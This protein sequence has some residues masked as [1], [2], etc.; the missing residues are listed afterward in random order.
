MKNYLKFNIDNLKRAFGADIEK[1]YNRSLRSKASKLCYGVGVL[2]FYQLAANALNAYMRKT[3]QQNEAEKA[4]KD[5]S[6]V[7]K[8]KLAYPDGMKWYD[9]LMYSNASG[10]GTHIFGGRYKDGK[11]MYIR[12]GKQFR[13]FP[14]MFFDDNWHLSFPA[15]IWERMF[16]KANP[17]IHLVS[18][19]TGFY[20]DYNNTAQDE[21]IKRKY[22]KE[23]GT[24][25]KL[26]NYYLPY[27]LNTQS[28]KEFRTTDLVFP[29]SKGYNN[30]KAQEDFKKYIMN[31]DTPGISKTYQNCVLNGI[32]PQLQMNAAIASIKAD[33]KTE[34]NDG[35]I[36]LGKAKEAFENAK[37]VEEKKNYK[38]KI[39]KYLANEN[40]GDYSMQ[41]AIDEAKDILTGQAP[42]KE[43]N[44]VYISKAT[45]QDVL[46][47][48]RLSSIR[49]KVK[50]HTDIINDLRDTDPA[51]AKA[52]Y[53]SH[54]KW[55]EIDNVIKKANKQ[56]NA[57]KK[58]MKKGKGDANTMNKIRETRTKALRELEGFNPTM[59]K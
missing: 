12:W 43:S 41:N 50:K 53:D 46:D 9:Y 8:Y 45:Y 22:G 23:V 24:L 20:S 58:L 47:D 16:T 3:D 44:D 11:E 25:V 38:N 35:I 49:T 51:K 4:A 19:L 10:K 13:E 6:Y 55:F 1:D 42:N 31:G 30:H 32:N 33:N 27:S 59:Y 54:R 7:D 34:M 18:D 21:E 15:Q 26:I 37:T 36:D 5:P 57:Y 48:Y 52:Y 17:M 39:L 14:E 40:Y 56:I 2:L 29:S 28:N